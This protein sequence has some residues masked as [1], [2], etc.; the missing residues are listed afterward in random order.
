MTTTISTDPYITIANLSAMLLDMTAALNKANTTNADLEDKVDDLSEKN[1]QLQYHLTN[2]EFDL[3]QAKIQLNDSRAEEN[4]LRD[5]YEEQVDAAAME[6]WEANNL[7]LINKEQQE[8]ITSLNN[9]IETAKIIMDEDASRYEE[10]ARNYMANIT[11]LEQEVRVLKA[12][13]EDLRV[14]Q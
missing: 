8:T 10:E 1:D 2:A 3:D 7:C 11:R 6:T 14:R 12:A 4:L 5:M 9:T 13:V